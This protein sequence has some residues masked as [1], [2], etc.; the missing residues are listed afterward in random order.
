ME[1]LESKPHDTSEERM[2]LVPVL[3]YPHVIHRGHVPAATRCQKVKNEAGEAVSARP[4]FSWPSLH[5]VLSVRIIFI[6][7]H[8]KSF[9]TAAGVF[10]HAFSSPVLFSFPL[11]KL[12]TESSTQ[13]NVLPLKI[14]L[15]QRVMV[16]LSP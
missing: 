10:L 2:L 12:M 7:S 13:K 6:Q 1:N 5:G 3:S 14:S 15:A 9:C 16:P 11:L 8:P 4:G